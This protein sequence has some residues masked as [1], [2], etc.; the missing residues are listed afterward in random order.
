MFGPMFGYE[1]RRT[2]EERRRDLEFADKRRSEKFLA[3]GFLKNT[4][5][6]LLRKSGA[7]VG[8]AGEGYISGAQLLV[9]VDGV[10]YKLTATVDNDC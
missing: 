6:P 8:L 9:E 2:P 10:T 7:D 4:V 1:D 5:R 3:L